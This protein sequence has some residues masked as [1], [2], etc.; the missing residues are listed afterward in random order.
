MKVKIKKTWI[1]KMK[2]AIKK[3]LLL[4]KKNSLQLK[5]KKILKLELSQ[6]Y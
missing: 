3:K 4:L 1:L 5:E 6:K 2:V